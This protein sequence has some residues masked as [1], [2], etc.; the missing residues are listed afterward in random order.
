MI[1]I[2]P[3]NRR[4]QHPQGLHRRQGV[5]ARMRQLPLKANDNSH[6]DLGNRAH[7]A[8]I[9]GRQGTGRGQYG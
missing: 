4:M 3:F 9:G 5:P 2:I 8:N 1:R 6:G 7:V